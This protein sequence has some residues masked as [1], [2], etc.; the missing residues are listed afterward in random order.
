MRPRAATIIA[1]VAL[2]A[3][4]G[5]SA[6]AAKKLTGKDIK[7]GSIGLKDL[8]KSAQ[9]ALEGAQGPRGAAGPSGAPGAQGPA[10][11]TGAAGAQGPAGVNRL[12]YAFGGLLELCAAGDPSCDVG[13]SEAVCPAG[14]VATGGGYEYGDL[15]PT[16]TVVTYNSSNADGNGWVVEVINKAAAA[17]DFYAVAHCVPGTIS[18]PQGA[19]AARR[20][21]AE[22]MSA[23]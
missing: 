21:A 15:R 19:K 2:F 3:V 1:F 8:S 9:R 11:P 18:P 13:Y 12:Q 20:A 23:N 6:V 17:M 22:R 4:L 7:D 14:M 10:G 16:D 5:G